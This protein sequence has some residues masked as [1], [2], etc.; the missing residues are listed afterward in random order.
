MI[1]VNSRK[2]S[3]IWLVVFVLNHLDNK[4]Q[5]LR[6]NSA[7]YSTYNNKARLRNKTDYKKPILVWYVHSNGS[8]N[9]LNSTKKIKTKY[10]KFNKIRKIYKIVLIPNIW[11]WWYISYY[12]NVV[13]AT[14]YCSFTLCTVVKLH[15]THDTR[16][17]NLDAP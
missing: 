11:H 14:H 5:V 15:P 4:I 17:D 13:L 3:I 7:K 10:N 1:I 12:H 8:F 16:Y 9:H 2:C 6:Y